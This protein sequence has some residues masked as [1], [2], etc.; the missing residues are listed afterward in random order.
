MYSGRQAQELGLHRLPQD[1]V[2][3]E[4]DRDMGLRSSYD[5]EQSKKAFNTLFTYDRYVHLLT[6]VLC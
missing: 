4:H 1:I 3:S 2:P 6:P 5:L